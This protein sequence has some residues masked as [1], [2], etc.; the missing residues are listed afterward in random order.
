LGFDANT[1]LADLVT[2]VI[3]IEVDI[4]EAKQSITFGDGMDGLPI[5]VC[6]GNT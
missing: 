3:V 2:T 6:L 5:V 4:G 1:Q